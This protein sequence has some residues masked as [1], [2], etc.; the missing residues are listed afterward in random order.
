MIF[1]IT[2]LDGSINFRVTAVDAAEA[3]DKLGRSL[4]YADFASMAQDLHYGP[5]SLQI[6]TIRRELA[7]YDA[8]GDR[9]NVERQREDAEVS[10]FKA[11]R[12]LMRS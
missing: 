10:A 12:R 3:L 4:R 5:G 7:E 11:L 9:L 6:A 1:W 8:N 2:S